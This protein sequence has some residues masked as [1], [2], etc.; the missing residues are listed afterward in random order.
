MDGEAGG[1]RAGRGRGDRSTRRRPGR[2]G[3]RHPVSSS[4]SPPV[5]DYYS[6]HDQTW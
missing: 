4:S 1:G 5:L 6:I 3:T 2:R